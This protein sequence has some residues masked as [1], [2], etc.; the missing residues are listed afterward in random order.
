MIKNGDK[1]KIGVVTYTIKEVEDDQLGDEAIAQ[2]FRAKDEIRVLKGLSENQKSVVLW[3]EIFH[4]I[5]GELDEVA[6]D[7]LAQ[8]MALLFMDNGIKWK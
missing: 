6:V 7:A 8:A 4:A 2:H 5:N 1:I 3:H